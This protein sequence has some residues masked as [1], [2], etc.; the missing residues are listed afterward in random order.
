VAEVLRLHDSHPVAVMAANMIQ[1]ALDENKPAGSGKTVKQIGEEA[2][3][4]GVELRALISTIQ[5]P[6]DDDPVGNVIGA[7]FRRIEMLEDE[8]A[9]FE[10]ELSTP[11]SGEC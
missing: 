1:Q 6:D 2:G 5:S 7:L 3:L 9:H 10:G 11:E 8:V 4:G